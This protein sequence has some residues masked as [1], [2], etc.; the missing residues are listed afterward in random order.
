MKYMKQAL[1]ILSIFLSGCLSE[2]EIKARQENAFDIAGTYKTTEDSEV[3]LNFT[4]TNQNVKHDILVQFNRTSPLPLTDQEKEL[5]SDLAKKHGVSVETLTSKPFPAIFGGNFDSFSK[6]MDGGEN[7]S[8]NFGK[9]SRFHVYSDNP[10][11]YESKK[12][13]EGGK[14]VKLQ[15][16]YSFS[17]T[18]KKES[19][20]VIEGKL[21]LDASYHYDTDTDDGFG[22]AFH[23]RVELNYKAEKIKSHN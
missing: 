18:V 8:S 17:G 7:I 19:K 3:Q 22:I 20:N 11:E 23:G 15:I 13:V 5:F 4:I 16:Q 21:S 14:N 9:T 12:V 10:P 2:E 6:S 1:I